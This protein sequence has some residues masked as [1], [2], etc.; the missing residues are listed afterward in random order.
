MKNFKQKFHSEIW[1]YIEFW[2]ELNSLQEALYKSSR[3]FDLTKCEVK[4]YKKSVFR[5]NKYENML[6]LV[7]NIGLF[8]GESSSNVIISNVHMI[9]CKSIFI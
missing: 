9:S 2:R 7:V 6:V 5:T 1:P 8:H 3:F 4:N